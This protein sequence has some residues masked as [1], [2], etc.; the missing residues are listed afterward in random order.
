MNEPIFL[1]QND[2]RNTLKLTLLNKDDVPVNLEGCSVRF[3]M[4]KDNDIVVDSEAIVHDA[5]NGIVWYPFQDG[6]LRES[7]THN[8][9]VEVT[10]PDFKIETFP[11]IGYISIVV[12]KDLG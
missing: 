4:K 7:G 2:T 9:E 1:K 8:A 3:L 11:T 12:S 10:Y 6:D 5:E